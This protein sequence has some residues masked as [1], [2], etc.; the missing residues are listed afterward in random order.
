MVIL[1]V[2]CFS[3]NKVIGHM[4]DK[5][6]SLTQEVSPNEALDQLGLKRICCRRMLLT[7]VDLIEKML[8][9]QTAVP[10]EGDQDVPP[11]R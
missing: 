5:W 1:A 11:N 8:D 4:W 6:T 10:D 7:H 2:K 3:C 9:Y